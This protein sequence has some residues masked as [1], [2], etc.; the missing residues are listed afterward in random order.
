MPEIISIP[1]K[2]RALG[3]SSPHYDDLLDDG[4]DLPKIPLLDEILKL[5]LSLKEWDH[6]GE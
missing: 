6:P 5:Q 3:H 1:R 2:L 4:Q